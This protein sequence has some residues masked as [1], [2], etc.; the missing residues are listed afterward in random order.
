MRT[1][2]IWDLKQANRLIQYGAHVLSVNVDY[3]SGKTYVKFES[4]HYFDEL[5]LKWQRKEI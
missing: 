5:M 1:L 2:K 4:D 3:K